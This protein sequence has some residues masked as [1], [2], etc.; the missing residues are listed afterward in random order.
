MRC[1]TCNYDLRKLSEHRCPECGRE[2]EPSDPAS[3]M[4]GEACSF[5]TF[6]FWAKIAWIAFVLVVCGLIGRYL[7][8]AFL[9]DGF[10]DR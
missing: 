10:D 5:D 4:D 9:F 3:F 7:F 1:L 6:I 2:F 8:F